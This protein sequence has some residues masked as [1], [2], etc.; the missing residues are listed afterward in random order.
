[1]MYDQCPKHKNQTNLSTDVVMCSSHQRKHHRRLKK[2]IRIVVQF[3]I[4][5]VQY[6]AC[7]ARIMVQAVR[8][9]MVVYSQRPKRK[10]KRLRKPFRITLACLECGGAA[11]VAVAVHPLITTPV[12]A[13]YDPIQTASAVAELQGQD[14]NNPIVLSKYVAEAFQSQSAEHAAEVQN[15]TVRLT[16]VAPAPVARPTASQMTLCISSA[17]SE[18]K[19]ND[20][21]T[22]NSVSTAPEQS[23]NVAGDSH[24]KIDGETVE[25]AVSV[26]E[27][28]RSNDGANTGETNSDNAEKK[29][30]DENSENSQSVTADTSKPNQENTKTDAKEESE[31]VKANSESESSSKEENG[32]SEVIA[33][34]SQNTNESAENRKE[35]EEK[36]DAAP[37]ATPEST[38]VAKAEENLD[39][40]RV[41]VPVVKTGDEP[42]DTTALNAV[43]ITALKSAPEDENKDQPINNG[44]TMTLTKDEVTID[45][46]AVFTP[47]SYV[48][49]KTVGTS[50][51]PALKIDSNVDTATDGQYGVSY[52]ATDISGKQIVRTLKVTVKTPEWVIEAR[53]KAEEEEKARQEAEQKAKEEEEARKK[54][55]EEAA[56]AAAAQARAEAAK[57]VPAATGS[58][59][60]QNLIATARQYLGS[61]YVWG[62]TSPSGFDCS[63][64][65]QYVFAMNGITLNRTAAAQA[66]NGYQISGSDA[67]AG[68]LMI[69][70]GHVALCEGNGYV[71]EAGNPSTGVYEHPINE[72]YGAGYFMGYYRIPGVN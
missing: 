67:R 41:L 34:G 5:A 46:G 2:P 47:E 15:N 49:I 59:S 14:I 52:T 20:E 55:E 72:G 53:K 70:S 6:T 40:D 3:P 19:Q 64:F 60:G 68:D 48:I 62:G 7:R 44:I 24:D 32:K 51:L 4:I 37:T 50:K 71:I 69:W 9:R 26:D 28:S 35:P 54:A 42:V 66:S 33:T 56:A 11:G 17:A 1:M 23:Q 12:Y 63:G 18:N 13:E 27:E 31:S 39:A 29:K 58:A 43:D 36:A 61:P 10:H 16:A 45:N 21:S 22:E 8:T 30:T 57:S 38:P 25:N 65:V